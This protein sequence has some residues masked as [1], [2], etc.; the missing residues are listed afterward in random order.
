MKRGDIYLAV[1]DPVIGS[2]QGGRRPVV[3]VQND[4]GNLHSP[5]VIAVPLTGSASKPALP[6]HALIPKGEGGLWLASTA[7]C[8]QVRTLEKTRLGRY[9]GTLDAARLKQVDRALMISLDIV[10]PEGNTNQ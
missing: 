8:E 1:L 9:L 5:T 2:E 3:I 4:T 10:C 6:T 7:L